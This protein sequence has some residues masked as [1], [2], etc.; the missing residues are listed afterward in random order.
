VIHNAPSMTHCWTLY[1]AGP[2]HSLMAGW[3]RVTKK[4][5]S[6]S[7]RPPC[8]PGLAISIAVWDA[9]FAAWL[10]SGQSAVCV[11]R[12]A[13]WCPQAILLPAVVGFAAEVS[14][15]AQSGKSRRKENR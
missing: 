14:F 1:V 8:T 6:G 13:S 5:G 3:R 15:G 10:P 9:R 4:L 2:L 12:C 11:V 7:V